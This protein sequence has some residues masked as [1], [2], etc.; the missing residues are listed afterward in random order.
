MKFLKNTIVLSLTTAS[1]VLATGV[2]AQQAPTP[3]PAQDSARSANHAKMMEQRQQRMQAGMEKHRT[4]LHDK[5]KLTPQQEPAWKAF[6]EATK[7][8]HD[9][10]KHQAKADRQAMA[11]MSAPARMEK[12]LERSK[13]RLARM[14]QHLDALKSFYAVLTPEQ[15][16]IFD[17]SHQRMH[18]RMKKRMRDGMQKRMQ[19]HMHDGKPTRMHQGQAPAPSTK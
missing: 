4:Q 13:E 9:Q 12:M 16:K 10:K 3:A 5:L 18:D 2:Y 6:T 15:Q 17:A 11:A 19:N 8:Q 7:P 14:Q 1:L